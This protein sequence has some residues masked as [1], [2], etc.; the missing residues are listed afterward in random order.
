MRSTTDF[1]RTRIL[2]TKIIRLTIE[3]GSMTGIQSILPAVVEMITPFTSSG[4]RAAQ[5]RPFH[6]VPQSSILHDSHPDHAQAIR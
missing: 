6:R 4:R 2:V 5:R 3:T 1:R